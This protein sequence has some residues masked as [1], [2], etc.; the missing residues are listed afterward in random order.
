MN[1][2]NKTKK[3]LQNNRH[4]KQNQNKSKSPVLSNEQ[5][6]KEIRSYVTKMSEVLQSNSRNRSGT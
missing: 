5:K 1:A 3:A 6:A 2:E 4:Q